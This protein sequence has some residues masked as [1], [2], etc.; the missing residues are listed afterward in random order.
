M[1]LAGEL[2]I[3]PGQAP[4]GI[5]PHCSSC[6]AEVRAVSRK[7]GTYGSDSE[8]WRAG[9]RASSGP[10]ARWG[11]MCCGV[12]PTLPPQLQVSRGV[13]HQRREGPLYSHPAG[14]LEVV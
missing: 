14:V 7:C 4:H 11:R 6:G 2:S 8:A 1:E 3:M 5:H 12:S 9:A 13:L 10:T